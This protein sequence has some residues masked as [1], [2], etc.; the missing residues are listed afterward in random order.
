MILIQ[1]KLIPSIVP[2]LKY[3]TSFCHQIW[4]SEK[5]ISEIRHTPTLL[6][7][8]EDDML[9]PPSHMKRLHDSIPSSTPHELVAIPGGDHNDTCMKPEYFPAIERFWRK[10]IA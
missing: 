5:A 1:P 4:N 8:G 10:Y 6:L 7:S 9:I 2:V 3:A